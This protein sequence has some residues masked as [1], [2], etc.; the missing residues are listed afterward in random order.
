MGENLAGSEVWI[1]VADNALGIDD[2]AR[3]RIFDPFFTSREDGTGLGLALCRKI[4]D[5][6]GGAIE[7]D[8]TPGEGAEFLLTFPKR[9]VR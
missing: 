6:H 3:Q 8:T 2:E 9:G 4:V 7:V 1:R 5:A